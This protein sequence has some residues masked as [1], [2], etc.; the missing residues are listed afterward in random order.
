MYRDRN[1]MRSRA[2]PEAR[3]SL[4][5][6]TPSQ[7]IGCYPCFT[8]L[9][10]MKHGKYDLHKSS[11][12][13]S[14]GTS[15]S[16]Y[17][18]KNENPTTRKKSRLRRSASDSTLFSDYANQLTLFENEMN[19]NKCKKTASDVTK[20][21]RIKYN[22]RN[23]KPVRME[24]FTGNFF[25]G[26]PLPGYENLEK[27]E[28]KIIYLPDSDIVT[29]SEDTAAESL[30]TAA[31]VVDIPEYVKN[32]IY[33]CNE[34]DLHISTPDY[35]TDTSFSKDSQLKSTS[36]TELRDAMTNGKP[37]DVLS[38]ILHDYKKIIKEWNFTIQDHCGHGCSGESSSNK[39]T[40]D[41]QSLH[42]TVSCGIPDKCLK[43]LTDNRYTHAYDTRSNRRNHK[44]TLQ[45]KT[46]SLSRNQTFGNCTT[47][48]DNFKKKNKFWKVD[49]TSGSECEC[50]QAIYKDYDRRLEQWCET[51]SQCSSL[52]NSVNYSCLSR[53][54]P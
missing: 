30:T 37:E 9:C 53:H 22:P 19:R 38:K 21:T 47:T 3:G 28:E 54:L 31:T 35:S 27:T 39:S 49:K 15:Y 12:N 42:S 4:H 7:S 36:C 6:R 2:E 46:Q 43:Y 50:L 52:I 14:V 25:Y 41:L 13:L 20:N 11:L 29:A 5:G 32:P 44:S 23:I 1:A 51:I 45:R 10:T 16:W 26:M 34:E 48:L 40:S 33:G 18:K 8:T 17:Y 24:P